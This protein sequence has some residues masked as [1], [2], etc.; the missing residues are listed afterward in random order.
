M[1]YWNSE[2][3]PLRLQAA[4]MSPAQADALEV[5]IDADRLKTGRLV[6][7]YWLWRFFFQITMVAALLLVM[8]RVNLSLGWRS[9]AKVYSLGFRHWMHRWLSWST[10]CVRWHGMLLLLQL[11]LYIV[12]FA[13]VFGP[14]EHVLFW[15]LGLLD[16]A[17]LLVVAT[18]LRPKYRR[19]SRAQYK[20]SWAT[21]VIFEW[22]PRD[23]L[24]RLHHLFVLMVVTAAM[25]LALSLRRVLYAS[26]QLAPYDSANSLG[27]PPAGIASEAS[28]PSWPRAAAGTA[29]AAAASAAAGTAAAAGGTGAAE[30]GIE[31]ARA[32]MLGAPLAAVD[33]FAFGVHLV[34][35]ASLASL[36]TYHHA[37]ALQ[38]LDGSSY[39]RTAP[40][41]PRVL[42]LIRQR[43]GARAS[44]GGRLLRE[45]DLRVV[46]RGQHLHLLGPDG[47]QHPRFFQVDDSF[48]QLRW[49]WREFLM[50]DEI[51]EVS[52]TA[53]QTS[54]GL[55]CRS[56]VLTTTNVQQRHTVTL[57]CRSAS[58]AARWAVALRGL[59]K[60]DEVSYDFDE[61][62]RG[63]L[64]RAFRAALGHAVGRDGSSGTLSIPQQLAFFAC[65]H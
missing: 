27:Y 43:R 3:S 10:T 45:E 13:S 25:Q 9:Y 12:R 31:A 26:G 47:R 14:A 2:G 33:L 4:A 20:Q 11:C 60:L 34:L 29:A 30:A 8:V 51:D 35:L 63:R 54:V 19:R 61:R 39:R 36:L 24:R 32:H 41:P 23:D 64:K 37:E 49:S 40:L 55:S 62:Q 65:S 53:G 52:H 1:S 5:V 38:F 48:T 44:H 50:L 28:L 15:V 21:R 46:Q 6:E 42:K 56:S 7:Q 58:D 59:R 57:T 22:F 18:L 17:S 16:A